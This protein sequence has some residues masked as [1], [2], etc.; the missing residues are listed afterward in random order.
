MSQPDEGRD[1]K[2]GRPEPEGDRVPTAVCS[3][4][5]ARVESCGGNIG[6]LFF[7]CECGRRWKQH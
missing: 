4:C 3:D 6:G 1:G 2:D 7:A 5:G